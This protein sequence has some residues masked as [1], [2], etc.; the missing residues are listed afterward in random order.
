MHG[1]C[2]GHA[3]A[4]SLPGHNRAVSNASRADTNKSL[5]RRPS[6]SIPRADALLALDS[7]SGNRD[8]LTV[9]EPIPMSNSG[10][11]EEV[12][13]VEND[14]A[15]KYGRFGMSDAFSLMPL[16]TIER[17][18]LESRRPRWAHRPAWMRRDRSVGGIG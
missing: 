14:D 5:P 3:R 6:E 17:H 2:V 11:G 9:L 12:G 18:S 10:S 13:E 4:V 1:V 8:G 16:P 15:G 7:R